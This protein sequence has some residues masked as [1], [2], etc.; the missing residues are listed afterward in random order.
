LSPFKKI[1]GEIIES[2]P[3]ADSTGKIKE[4]TLLF[5]P[6]LLVSFSSC[7]FLL[8]EKVLLARLSIEEMEAAISVAYICQI[9]QIVCISLAMMAQVSVAGW[10]GSENWKTIGPGIWQFIW[11]SFFSMLITVPVGLTY[12]NYFLAHTSIQEIARPYFYFLSCINFIY[13]LGTA[14]S[15]F[16]LGRGKTRLVLFTSVGSQILKIALAIPLILGYGS[17]IPSFG[18]LGG[19]ISTLL[20]Q[21]GYCIVLFAAF[22]KAANREKFASNIWKFQPKFFW[23]CIK[24]GIL[25]AANRIL[26]VTCWASIAQLMVAKGGDYLIILSIGGALSLFLPFLGDAICQTQTIIVSQMIGAKKYDLLGKALFSGILLS[27]IFILIISIILV[28]FSSFIFDHLFTNVTLNSVM[29]QR[30]FLGVWLSFAFYTFGYVGISYI[31]AFKDMKFSLFMGAFNWVNGYLLMYI[32]LEKIE[33]G[34]DWFWLVL[35]IMHGSTTLLY[36]LRTKALCARAAA[37]LR[38]PLPS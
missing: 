13:P 7:L 11:F 1:T 31:L 17:W 15:C 25:R 4:F 8:V 2:Q 10:F 34:P 26:N 33:I 14:L 12:G 5:I 27:V 28:G 19:A 32:A 38:L 6:I 30:V 21:G 36:F 37:S 35:S 23:E 24:P 9:F 16:Y 3:L 20:A 18:L 29:V 22:F